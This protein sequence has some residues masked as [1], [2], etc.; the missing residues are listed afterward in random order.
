MEN[1]GAWMEAEVVE[2][3]L[4]RRA[5]DDFL[6]RRQDP[7]LLEKAEGNQFTAKVFPIAGNADKHIV[8][9]YS[10]ELAGSR[11]V[12]PLRGLP[13]TAR[14]DIELASLSPSGAPITQQL[15]QRDWT[16]DRDFLS[17]APGAA[18][19]VAAGNLV[20]TQVAAVAPGTA[21]EPPKALTLLVDTS[22]SRAL[23]YDGYV[24]SVR[25]LIDK[26]AARYGAKLPLEVVAFDQDHQS[27]YRGPA[28]GWGDAEDRALVE[29]GA[30]GA[31]DLAQ[32]L[33]GLHV[34]ARLVVVTDGVITA[35]A[36]HAE[37]EAAVRGVKAERVDVVLAGGIRDD[38]AAN[39]LVRAGAG[40]AGAV[41]DLDDGSGVVAD[42]L[43]AAGSCRRGGRHPG[44]GVG[45]PEND[46][47][48][49]RGQPHDGAT[50]ASRSRSA[51]SIW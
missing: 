35:G 10:Q 42:E 13:R 24:R 38:A 41:L 4:A 21:S 47:I 51:T 5:Y 17:D 15:H 6:H 18:L 7:A 36:E 20:A 29:R 46:R 34:A 40:H 23:G 50:R 19:A 43:G 26:L 25:A 33:R 22:A 45:V 30:A 16:P 2:K 14:V 44:G 8:I 39:E 11:Y 49:A 32:A 28:S 3:Q 48:G 9:S 31:S 27:I 12:L 37:L 1:D